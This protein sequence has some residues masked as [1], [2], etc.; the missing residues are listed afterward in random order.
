MLNLR[1]I[2]YCGGPPFKI[3][4]TFSVN[5]CVDQQIPNRLF[6]CK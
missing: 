6:T 5:A 4:Y 2:Y 3:A 1:L